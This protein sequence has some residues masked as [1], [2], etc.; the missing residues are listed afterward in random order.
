[1]SLDG[2]PTMD[3]NDSKRLRRFSLKKYLFSRP[4]RDHLIARR[5]ALVDFF[6]WLPRDAVARGGGGGG[7]FIVHLCQVYFITACD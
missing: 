5:A 7:V 3:D 6:S 4:S 2:Q 1:M